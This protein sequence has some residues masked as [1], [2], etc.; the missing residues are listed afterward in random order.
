[1]NSN[2]S[3]FQEKNILQDLLEESIMKEK[4]LSAKKKPLVIFY[5]G[6]Y[7]SLSKTA[8]YL[9]S[10]AV[11]LYTIYRIS[12]MNVPRDPN[13]IAI[14]HCLYSPIPIF[15]AGLA[16]GIIIAFF[17]ASMELRD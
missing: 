13:Y 17:I 10:L 4:K 2:F 16:L 5:A 14:D 8:I 1:M 6:N 11:V 7:T 12:L 9:G 15:I 3:E